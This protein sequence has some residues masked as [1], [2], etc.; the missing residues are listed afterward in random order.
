M[1]Q[2]PAIKN[3]HPLLGIDLLKRPPKGRVGRKAGAT[4]GQFQQLTQDEMMRVKATS[5]RYPQ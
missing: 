5:G 3:I 1:P 2:G 4:G